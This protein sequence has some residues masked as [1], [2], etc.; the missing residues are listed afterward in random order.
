MGLRMLAPAIARVIEDR[1]GRSGAAERF[2]VANTN[3]APPRVGL[4][5]CQH[6]HGGVV[7]V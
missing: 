2:V 3:P 4:A 5:F 6:G 7:T 1:G